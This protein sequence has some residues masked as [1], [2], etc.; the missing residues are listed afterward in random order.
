MY[1]YTY[2]SLAIYLSVYIQYTFLDYDE[3]ESINLQ[4]EKPGSILLPKFLSSISRGKNI[5]FL[6]I[7]KMHTREMKGIFVSCPDVSLVR[8]AEYK[9]HF[10]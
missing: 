1:I 6:N 3:N 9:N 5:S 10:V 7:I 8:E 4:K 2:I